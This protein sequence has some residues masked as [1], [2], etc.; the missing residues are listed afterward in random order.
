MQLRWPDTISFVFQLFYTMDFDVDIVELSCLIKGWSWNANFIFQMSM[1]IFIGVYLLVKALGSALLLR[2]KPCT[3]MI[4]ILRRVLSCL[5]EEPV[6]GDHLRQITYA[7]LSN[8]IGMTN[9]L[10]ASPTWA[11]APACTPAHAPACMH[12]YMH[13]RV[14]TRMQACNSALL[15]ARTVHSYAYGRPCRYLTLC[16]YSLRPFRCTDLPWAPNANHPKSVLTIN[17]EM[18]CGSAEHRLYQV[19]GHRPFFCISV[20]QD[21]AQ[22]AKCSVIGSM[23]VQE[24]D[25]G[26][27]GGGGGGGAPWWFTRPIFRCSV[28]LGSQCTSLGFLSWSVLRYG[29]STTIGFTATRMY[30]IPL[31][32]YAL[33]YMTTL[34]THTCT[35]TY[36]HID[37]D[38]HTCMCRCEHT[39]MHLRTHARTNAHTDACLHIC[40]H[41]C[42]HMHAV[43]HSRAHPRTYTSELCG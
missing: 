24:G 41:T 9:V 21:P 25:R 40:S 33:A 42:T 1:P 4:S 22:G 34:A 8:L 35:R 37:A 39:L 2:T 17:A 30:A 26:G 19:G 11:P 15:P 3:G 14:H 27:G 7:R 28:V 29:T 13:A 32:K 31:H 20:C 6:D 12:A 38:T 18:V 5:F 10:Y 43:T 36:M 16:K 23:P